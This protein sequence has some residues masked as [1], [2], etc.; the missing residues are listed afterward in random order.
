MW[1]TS[2]AVHSVDIWEPSHSY[3][4]GY[5]SQK[6]N[7]RIMKCPKSESAKAEYQTSYIKNNKEKKSARTRIWTN[8]SKYETGTRKLRTRRRRTRPKRWKELV[9]IGK[10]NSK[11][12]T[13]KVIKSSQTQ[14]HLSSKN[15]KFPSKISKQ[16][17]D[18][19]K[20]L[21]LGIESLWP[22]EAETNVA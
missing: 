5:I 7:Q 14:N 9:K 18:N 8:K 19:N 11:N 12:T 16:K 15:W 17:L 3:S 4:T 6:E 21:R 2:P 20:E 13:S 10:E 22:I 1:R